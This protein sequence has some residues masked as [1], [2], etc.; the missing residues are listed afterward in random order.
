[1]HLVYADYTWPSRAKRLL[2]LASP[3]PSPIRHYVNREPLTKSTFIDSIH[4]TIRAL[5]FPYLSR[6][7]LAIASALELQLQQQ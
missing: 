4:Q 7:L 3:V 5:D 6:S 1:M 2:G